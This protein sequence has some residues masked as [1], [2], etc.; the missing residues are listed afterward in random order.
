MQGLSELIRQITACYVE[1]PDNPDFLSVLA[2]LQAQL[3]FFIRKHG[4][5]TPQF[6]AEVDRRSVQLWRWQKEED[7][8]SEMEQPCSPSE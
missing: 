7:Q 6:H 1:H 3:Q 5:D 2:E 8:A 4:L